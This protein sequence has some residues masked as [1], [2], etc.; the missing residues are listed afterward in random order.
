MLYFILGIFCILA[1]VAYVATFFLVRD[2]IRF[3]LG[4]HNGAE[5]GP[6]SAGLADGWDLRYAAYGPCP[7]GSE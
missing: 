5:V 6:P 2:V 3:L 7:T 1:L 4:S